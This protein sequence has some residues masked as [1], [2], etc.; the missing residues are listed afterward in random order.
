V[1]RARRLRKET[2]GERA[3]RGRLLI[4]LCLFLRVA[5]GDAEVMQS[6]RHPNAGRF[7]PATGSPG[8]LSACAPEMVVGAGGVHTT[9]ATVV[10]DTLPGAWLSWRDEF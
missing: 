6:L 3:V 10:D 2:L 1:T 7:R 4:A 9:I 8:V 5:D